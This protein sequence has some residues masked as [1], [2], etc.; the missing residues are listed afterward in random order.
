MASLSFL[1]RSPLL[2]AS[3]SIPL[4]ERIL[5]ANHDFNL[6]NRAENDLLLR[7]ARPLI[8]VIRQ[9]TTLVNYKFGEDEIGEANA[10]L[11]EL[12]DAASVAAPDID[13]LRQGLAGLGQRLHGHSLLMDMSVAIFTMQT[14]FPIACPLLDLDSSSV[15]SLAPRPLCFAPRPFR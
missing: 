10:A 13:L 4:L 7:M 11:E 14:Y 2:M 15:L 12:R 5:D 1:L 8:L 6:L 9:L 3:R